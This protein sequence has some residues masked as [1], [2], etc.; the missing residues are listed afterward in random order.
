MGRAAGW[1]FGVIVLL[2]V[3]LPTGRYLL[4]AAWEE[5]IILLARRPITDV[6]GDDDTDAATRTK[7][8]VVLAARAFAAD[9]MHLR[10]GDSFTE[11]TRLRRDTLVLVLSG[12]YRDQLKRYTWWFPV[13]GRVPYKGF[14]DFG[15]ARVAR[16]HLADDGFDT[17]LRPAS[18][19]STL[20]FFNDPVVSTTLAGDSLELANTVIHEL[21]HNTFYAPGQAVFN[22]SFANFVGSRGAAWFFRGRSSFDAAEEV[23]ARW[24]DE[25]TLGRFWTALHHEID[26]A[27]Q[28]HPGD[29]GAARAARLAVRDTIYRRARVQLVDS[30]GPKLRTIGPRY[31]ERVALDNAALLARRVYLTD[32]DLFDAVYAREGR[33]LPRTVARIVE[34]AK[35][36][37]KDPY[38]ALRRWLAAPR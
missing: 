13:V 1:T 2:L 30:L 12:A 16:R 6:I 28:A 20:G 23:E 7:L 32:L 36:D 35:G 34:L 4:R 33:D 15:A 24:E 18:A 10:T 17:S 9:S 21:T 27:F 31:L 11:Y 14:F 3:A 8:R 26:S 5:S 19:F 29:D 38:E 22:E 25:K 37:P